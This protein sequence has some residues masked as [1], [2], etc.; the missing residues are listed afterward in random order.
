MWFGLSKNKVSLEATIRKGAYVV[1]D[2]IHVELNLS[3][4][5]TSVIIEEIAF[6]LVLKS[7]FTARMEQ[8]NHID[9]LAIASYKVPKEKIGKECVLSADLIVPPTLPTTVGICEIMEHTYSVDISTTVDSKMHSVK[10]I[11]LPVIIG[12]IPFGTVRKPKLVKTQSFSL[13]NYELGKEGFTVLEVHLTFPFRSSE[14]Q[15]SGF[16]GSLQELHTIR[17]QGNQGRRRRNQLSTILPEV[18]STIRSSY[19]YTSTNMIRVLFL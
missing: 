10:E 17:K 2:V 5:T 3:N 6:R 9:R 1:G 18:S 7:V 8:M 14:L 4:T 12:V 19:S 11:K 13:D 15:D 16:Y